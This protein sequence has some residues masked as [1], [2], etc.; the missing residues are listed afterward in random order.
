MAS[1]VDILNAL[2]L[3]TS[4]A[5]VEGQPNSPLGQLLT[6]LANDV[7]KQLTDSMDSYNIRASNNLRQS[8]LPTKVEVNGDVVTVGISAPFY[9]K[10]VNY[11]VNGFAVNHGAPNWGS[12]GATREDFKK[13][14][15]AW[16][17]NVGINLNSFT[18]DSGKPMFSSY[19]KLDDGLMYMVA[20]N[21]Q[22]P[23]PFY[24]DVVND[25]LVNYLRKP[26]EKLFKKAM[27]VVIV[28]PWQ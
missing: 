27:T 10:Y 21:G 13:S 25:K 3:G 2:N 16:R 26:I 1:E 19:D 4:K 18:N 17:M 8:I 28:D 14:I 9:W 11:G 5:V 6:T 24:T 23:R 20:K 12:T 15:G 22:K 7:T